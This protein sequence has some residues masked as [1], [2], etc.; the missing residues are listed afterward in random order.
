MC[1][2]S[3]PLIPSFTVNLK[4]SILPGLVTIGK[5]DGKNPS[6]A[7]ASTQ[8]SITI[9]SPHTR[10]DDAKHEVSW[11]LVW[12]SAISAREVNNHH[13]SLYPWK[14]VNRKVRRLN[15]AH[16]ISSLACGP[17]VTDRSTITTSSSN[18]S[19]DA[20]AKRPLDGSSPSTSAAPGAVDFLLVGSGTHLQAYDVESNSDL[21]FKEVS[22]G[23][24]AIYGNDREHA[25]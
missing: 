8:D 7:Y 9:Y 14:N 3:M 13:D 2:G 20:E 4:D 12:R 16:N 19:N 6:V 23:S 17:L 5:F 21:F 10:S 18:N 25:T 15:I 22:V 24:V 11:K 1:F